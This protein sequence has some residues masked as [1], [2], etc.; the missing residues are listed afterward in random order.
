MTKKTQAKRSAPVSP[1]HANTGSSST[2]LRRPQAQ[3]SADTQAKLIDAAIAC[4][5]RV[6]YSATTV[7]MVAEEA[8]VSRGAMSHQFP[9]K[10]DLML[11]VVEAVFEADAKYYQSTVMAK[12]PKQWVLDLPAT[13]WEAVS[14]PSGTAVMEIML[15]SRSDS[16]LADKLRAKQQAIDARSHDW[17]IERLA[18]AGLHDRPNGEAVHR[19]F[20]A[21]I[22]GLSME[23]LFRRDKADSENS[24]AVLG[25]ILGLLYP[26]RDTKS[27]KRKA[28]SKGKAH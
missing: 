18:A 28:P 13:V 20:V 17:I 4:L 6:G 16:E 23:A 2:P 9:A 22:R 8:K 19:L 21:A 7:T 10:T 15:A 27:S 11:A 24:L 12:S 1:A 14:R 25:E 3:R 5:H 26:A